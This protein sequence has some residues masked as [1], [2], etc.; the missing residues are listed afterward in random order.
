MSRTINIDVFD[1]ASVQAAA[2]E[3]R[4]Y[5]DWLREKAKELARRLADMGAVNVSL[6]FSRAIYTGQNDV[7]VTVEERGENT[8]AI[9]A[10]GETVLILEFGAGVT[11]GY[12]HPRA[13]E[14]GYGPGTYPD[15]KHAMDPNGWY[16]PREKGGGHTYG[17]APVMA[18]YN[19][20]KGLR[21]EVERIAAEVFK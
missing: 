4:D 16:L 14:L 17:N 19:T 9:V 18:V 20:A 5:A 2:R 8:F 7:S 12:G 15:Q 21:E 11:Y 13:G 1:Y 10:S 3:M 6:E